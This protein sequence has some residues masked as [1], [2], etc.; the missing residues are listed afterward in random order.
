MINYRKL[1]IIPILALIVG[2][3]FWLEKTKVKPLPITQSSEIP[4]VTIE[5]TTTIPQVETRPEVKKTEKKYERVKEITLPSGFINTPAFK[6]ADFVGKK[7]ILVD[8]W[9]Y[10][11][12]NCQRTQPYLNAWYEKYHDKGL[13]IIG[14]HTPEFGF[15]KVYAN[16]Q[17]AVTEAGIKYPVVLDNDYGTWQAYGN[18]FWPRKYLVDLEGNIVFDHVGE[19]AYD[20]TER[21]IQELLAVKADLA[22]PQLTNKD[23]IGGS[24]TPEIYL[25][26]SRANPQNPVELKGNWVRESEFS[27]GAAGAEIILNYAAKNVFMVAGSASPV[28]VKVYQDDVFLKEITVQANALYTLVENPA[29]SAH[30]LRLLVEDP[31]FEIFTFTFG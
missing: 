1:L 22:T 11:C 26:T 21:K 4:P 29:P 7:V 9:T 15:E 28:K 5:S 31:G 20:L 30:S 14:V 3:I 18:R 19:G 25:G 17:K 27:R 16:V 24:L 2:A 10:T 6:I 12:I 8:F 13:E 23:I